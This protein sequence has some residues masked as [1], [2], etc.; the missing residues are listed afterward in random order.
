MVNLE[1]TPVD[2]ALRAKMQKYREKPSGVGLLEACSDNPVLFCEHMLGVVPFTWQIN[3]MWTVK[4]AVDAENWDDVILAMTSRQIGKSFTLAVLAL[5][6]CVFNKMPDKTMHNTRVAIVSR[7]DQQA[8]TL[9]KEV[10]FW[11]RN[12]DRYM[13][14]TYKDEEGNS[15]FGKQF[16]TDL[17]DSTEENNQRVI[18]FKSAEQLEHPILLTN[19]KVG[20]WIHS[21]PPTAIVLG[22]TFTVGMI[23]EAAHS[24][25]EEDFIVRELMPTGSANDAIWISTSTPWNASGWFYDTLHR[26]KGVR[27]FIYDIES[28]KDEELGQKQYKAAMRDIENM[29]EDGKATDVNMIYYCKFEKGDTSYF[30]PKKVVE[31]F[32]DDMH[33]TEQFTGPCDLGV[34]FGG[35]MNSHSVLTVVRYDEENDTIERLYH[36]RYPKNKDDTIVEDIAKLLMRFNIQRIIPDD[37]PQGDYLIREMVRRGW[38]VQPVK[39]GDPPRYGMNFRSDKVRKYGAFRAKL[40]RGKVKSYPDAVL[41]DELLGME[42]SQT[43]VQS[44][45]MAAKGS[46]DDMVDSFIMASYF[47]LSE[48]SKRVGVLDWNTL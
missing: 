16:F 37:C 43:S 47:M 34:D 22:E 18:T 40:H 42:N 14:H 27:R 19:S 24:S 30:D 44:R 3:F 10:K 15:V 6:L 12:G 39:K 11:M 41:R 29:R 2:D 23:D 33:M 46:T 5:W 32:D 31:I 36:H 17:V 28:I 4:E 7:G 13:R 35:K 8:R 21:Y 48:D 45:I 25:I 38:N 1:A 9:L 26:D 20:S